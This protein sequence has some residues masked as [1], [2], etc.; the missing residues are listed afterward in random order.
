M[1]YQSTVFA[2]AGSVEEAEKVIAKRR[3]KEAKASK[4]EAKKARKAYWKKQSKPARK[5]VKQNMKR[6]KKA[7]RKKRKQG[8]YDYKEQERWEGFMPSEEADTYFVPSL[9]K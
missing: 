8:E 3:K 9:D 5:S 6:Q 2:Q 7:A 1:V 4:R